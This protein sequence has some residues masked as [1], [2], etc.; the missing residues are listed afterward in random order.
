MI[1]CVRLWQ[2]H[3]KTLLLTQIEKRKNIGKA[4]NPKHFNRRL[5]I[6]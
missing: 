5:K 1:L 3:F 4:G 6:V 2:R